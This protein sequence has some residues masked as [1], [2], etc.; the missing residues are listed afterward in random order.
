MDNIWVDRL[1]FF[2]A[3]PAAILS[4]NMKNIKNIFEVSNVFKLF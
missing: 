2:F 1:F 4:K 3:F